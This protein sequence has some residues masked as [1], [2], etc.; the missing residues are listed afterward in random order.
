MR[1]HTNREFERELRQLRERLLA[2]GGRAEQQIATAMSALSERDPERA[3]LVIAA[4]GRIDLDEREIDELAFA[5]IARR[6][7]VAWRR[8][9]FSPASP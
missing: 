4:D 5:I 6:Q 8:W 3:E 7:P 1:Q 2:M 9:C